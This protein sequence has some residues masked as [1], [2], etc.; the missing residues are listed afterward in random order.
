MKI[1]N[2]NNQF[3]DFSTIPLNY[4]ISLIC[5]QFSQ[6][7]TV[8][9]THSLTNAVPTEPFL[10]IELFLNTRE[11][12]RFQERVTRAKYFTKSESKF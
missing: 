3:K 8:L 10:K 9:K 11:Q 1:K 12:I 7:Q 2:N 4:N 5:L 6:R